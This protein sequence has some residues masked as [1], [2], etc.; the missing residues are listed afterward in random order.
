MPNQPQDPLA[1][2]TNQYGPFSSALTG[3]L[4]PQNEAPP[5]HGAPS[6]GGAI[7]LYLGKFL[8]GAQTAQR[9]NFERSEQAKRESEAAMFRYAQ[10]KMADP[11]LSPEGKAAITSTLNTALAQQ[12]QDVLKGADKGNKGQDPHP[13][14]ALTQRITNSVLGPG[15]N[16]KHKDFGALTASLMTIGE[17]PKYKI[18]PNAINADS[19]SAPQQQGQQPATAVLVQP[20][21]QSTAAPAQAAS[22][23]QGYT[24]NQYPAQQASSAQPVA[25][26]V[27]PQATPPP[28]GTTPAA[29]QPKGSYTTQSEAWNDP[30]FQQQVQALARQ[31]ID[32]RGTLLGQKF[33]S[34]PKVGIAKPIG[35]AQVIKDPANP[36][37]SI[38]VQG[39]QDPSTGQVTYQTVG[40]AADTATSRPVLGSS[41]VTLT[42][43]KNLSKKGAAFNILDDNGNHIALEDIPSGMQLQPVMDSKRGTYYKPVTPGQVLTIVGNEVYSS[44]SQD[45][46]NVGIPGANGVA[47]LGVKNTGSSGTTEVPVVDNQGNTV[48]APMQN[49]RTPNTIGAKNRPAPPGVQSVNPTQV[50]Q[51]ATA[52][53]V[54][55]VTNTAPVRVPPPVVPSPA[56]TAAAIPPSGRLLPG[57]QAGERNTQMARLVPVRAASMQMFGDPKQ[58]GTK[59][60]VDFAELADNPVAR[61]K[62]GQALKIAFDDIHHSQAA[63]GGFGEWLKNVSGAQAEIESS[64]AK[65]L[66]DSLKDLQSIPGATDAFNATLSAYSSAIGLRSISKASGSQT[67]AQ[68]IERDL[69]MIGVNT[70][71][72]RD[73]YDKLSHYAQEVNDGTKGLGVQVFEPGEAAYFRGGIQAKLEHLKQQAIDPSIKSLP[74]PKAGITLQVGGT[75]KGKVITGFSQNGDIHTQ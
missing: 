68:A 33:E 65:V 8:Q 32:W 12:A 5:L 38:R 21:Q 2:S 19:I 6:T 62:L 49:T 70:S 9:T 44:T 43:A 30:G 35:T 47:D 36:N 56:G 74:I 60:L 72:S 51:P 34:L 55:P 40:E 26:Q 45:R 14:L 1:D 20:Q 7:A 69:P 48:A 22:V 37:R 25:G 4:T 46:G 42:D 15:E 54:A 59:S 57:M 58:P 31:G 67:S 13:L 27:A 64:R 75:Y 39:Y 41:R 17:D 61:E 18:N 53:V 10:S 23:A 63:S 66:Q 50:A 52:P 28:P 24:A 3:P 73:V 16:P 71:G 11:T 29:A